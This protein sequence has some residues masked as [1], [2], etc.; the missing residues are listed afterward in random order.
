M[1]EPGAPYFAFAFSGEVHRDA[2]FEGAR[3]TS[4]GLYRCFPITRDSPH[5]PWC[6]HFEWGACDCGP[7]E[8]EHFV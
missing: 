7:R 6:H 8:D 2:P 1:S 3:L 4:A 5:E